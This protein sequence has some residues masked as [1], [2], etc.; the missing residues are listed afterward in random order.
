M[1]GNMWSAWDQVDHFLITTNSTVKSNGAVVMGR[2]IARQMRDQF[3]GI[4]A[5]IGS[6][7][8]ETCGSGGVYGTIIGSKIGVFQVKR[9]WGDEASPELIAHSAQ[10]LTKHAL[11]HSE[12]TYA[13][14]F[15]GIGNGK[16]AYEDVLPLL[17]VLPFNV[18]VWTFN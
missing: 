17:N 14:N 18:Q 9:F 13:L 12:K 10:M 4:D 3:P 7:I 11:E 15:P 16:L 2:G 6:K 8:L 5:E 1:K